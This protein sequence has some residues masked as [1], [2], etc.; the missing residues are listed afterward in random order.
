M[1]QPIKNTFVHRM[2]DFIGKVIAFI[3]KLL[4]FL[5]FAEKSNVAT[6]QFGNPFFL[7]LC[8]KNG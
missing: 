5:S 6:D 1:M 8:N 7:F 4:V 2:P 3:K